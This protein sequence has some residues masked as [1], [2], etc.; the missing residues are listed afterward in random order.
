MSR[1]IAI[2]DPDPHFSRSLS[3]RLY[4]YLPDAK[5]VSYTP[6]SLRSD[7]RNFNEDVIL[8]DNH[9]TDESYLRQHCAATIL[10]LLIP[11]RCCRDD[12]GRRIPGKEITTKIID[13]Q[14][15][16]SSFAPDFDS[17]PGTREGGRLCLFLSLGDRNEREQYI[18]SNTSSMRSS[19]C[20]LIRLDLMPGISMPPPQESAPGQRNGSSIS[21]GVSDLLLL[22]ES[23]SVSPSELL[24]YLCPDGSG[25]LHFGRPVR[26]DD[27]IESDPV[28]LVRLTRLLRDLVDS[29]S[30]KTSVVIAVEGLSLSRAA[31]LCPLAHELHVILPHNISSSDTLINYELEQLFSSLSP[32][33]L[34]FVSTAR[35]A[36]I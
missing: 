5:I 19:G 7:P 31:R 29:A 36:A 15:P 8:F 6:D 26:S 9:Q 10:P 34:K 27:I 22:L 30:E 2:I 21:S 18:R 4:H 3:Q 17:T 32:K 20:R 33:Q 13:A 28:I 11:L 23:A 35:K 25:W 16:L 14:A 24:E 1:N 12:G